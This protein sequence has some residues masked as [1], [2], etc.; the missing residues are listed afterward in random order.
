MLL[1][2]ALLL[3][4]VTVARLGEYRALRLATGLPS[5]TDAPTLLFLF[6]PED[7]PRYTGLVQRWNSL[8]RADELRVLGIGIGFP[9][10]STARDSILGGSR[11]SFEVR[12][13]LD[14]EARRLLGRIGQGHTPTS[15]LLDPAGRPVFVLA[16]TA[17]PVVQ[18]EARRIIER[19]VAVLAEARS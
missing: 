16:P 8:A 7:C 4:G 3:A 14:R 1:F 19:Y 10:A 2:A 11:P 15:V 12:Y 6:Q 13:D 17:D 18:S 9:S 5:R